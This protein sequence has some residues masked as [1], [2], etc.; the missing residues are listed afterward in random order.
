MALGATAACRRLRAPRASPDGAGLAGKVKSL[1]RSNKARADRACLM[2]GQGR[3]KGVALRAH[4]RARPWPPGLPHPRPD[5]KT[6]QR[7]ALTE[8]ARPGAGDAALIGRG[9]KAQIFGGQKH[10]WGQ[11]VR[12]FSSTGR[13]R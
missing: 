1:A 4:A 13:L 10:I 9:G 2:R 8:R 12:P 6:H 3:R 11:L 5:G 7:A